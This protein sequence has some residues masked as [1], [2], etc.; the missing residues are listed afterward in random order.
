MSR[1][2][3]TFVAASSFEFLPRE[4]DRKDPGWD[5]IDS[6]I[7]EQPDESASV[8]TNRDSVVKKGNYMFPCL[9]TR[10]FTSLIC[11]VAMAQSGLASPPKSISTPN[12]LPDP[13]GPVIAANYTT[14]MVQFCRPGIDAGLI[15]CPCSNPPS[16]GG[17]LGCNNFGIGPAQSGTLAVSLASGSGASLADDGDGTPQAILMAT[18]ENSGALTVFFAGKTPQSSTGVANG[19]GVRCVTQNLKRMYIKSASGGGVSGGSVNAPTG[20]EDSISLRTSDLGSAISSGETR[21][22]YNSYRD[23]QAASPCGST[24]STI[25]LTNGAAITWGP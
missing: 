4:G 14:P 1:L 21:L 2:S 8:R 16:G 3:L 15:P 18:G 20:A 10:T 7:G 5:R 11:V 6:R 13:L 25:N 17:G 22:Y 23:P 12:A 19:A 9:F 24:S